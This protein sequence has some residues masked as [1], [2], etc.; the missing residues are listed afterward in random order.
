VNG[1]ENIPLN[2]LDFV[3]T[4]VLRFEQKKLIEVNSEFQSDFDRQIATVRAQLDAQG[5]SEFKRSDGALASRSFMPM[6]QLHRLVTTKTKVLEIVWSYLYSDRE[7]EA[8]NALTDM[9][10][11]R[12]RSNSHGHPGCTSTWR[13]QSGRWCF[14]PIIARSI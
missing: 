8:W 3:P 6:D 12:L 9:A 7:Q 10:F 13:P 1:F 2:A 11:G 5:L 4:V 14:P